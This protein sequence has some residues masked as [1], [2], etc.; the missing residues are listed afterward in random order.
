[1][2]TYEYKVVAAPNRGEKA[3]DAK[4]PADRYARALANVMNDL[5]RD[6]WEYLRADTLPSEERAGL[7]KR[8]TVYHSVLVFR[9][10]VAQRPADAAPRTLLTTEAQAGEAPR[11]GP[12]TP[13]AAPEPDTGPEPLHGAKAD[14]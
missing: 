3:R 11:I 7:T 1:M 2:Q 5:A 6:G 9:R 8:V 10:A 4:T 12:A 13:Q 14:T